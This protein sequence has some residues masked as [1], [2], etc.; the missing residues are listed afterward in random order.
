M[1]STTDPG[2][3]DLSSVI[4]MSSSGV[5]WA[6][7]NKEGLLRHLPRRP[8]RL[9][10]FLRS[11][12]YGRVGVDR[13]AAVARRLASRSGRPAGCSPRM[14]VAWLPGSGGTWPGGGER[15]HPT[16][17]LQ[18]R[19]Q[20]GADVPHIEGQRW[21]VP[22]DW[23]EVNEDGTLRA[24]RPRVGV[25][26]HRWREGVP[27]GSRGGAQAAPGVATRLR[28]VSPTTASARRSAPWSRP[29]PVRRPTCSTLA[30]HVKEHLAHYKAPRHLVLVDTIG[31]APNGKVDYKR[32][33]GVAV[34]RLTVG[35]AR[36]SF[37]RRSASSPNRISATS[38]RPGGVEDV[39]VAA[40]PA[41]SSSGGA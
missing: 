21:S 18:G 19:G 4:M 31:R 27:R 41:R 28:S 24:A 29:R 13:G 20:D 8:V 34:D 38:R 33:K 17:L 2:K 36:Y 23:A 32:L 9:V 30:D 37:N 11:G 39:V 10:R 35:S 26:Q 7:D 16:R 25:H 14:V 40:P 6:Q 12:R 1:R 22:G 3:Y 5:M 15:L